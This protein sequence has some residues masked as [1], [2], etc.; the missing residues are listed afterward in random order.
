MSGALL[1][2]RSD[3]GWTASTTIQQAAAIAVAGINTK[4]AYKMAKLQSNIAQQQ[5]T[6]ANELQAHLKENYIPCEIKLLDALCNTVEPVADY[7]QQAG[8]FATTTR[9]QFAK[10]RGQLEARYSRFCCG[11]Y[12][13]MLKDVSVSEAVA[14]AD[15]INYGFRIAEARQQSLSDVRHSRLFAM[16]G[17]GRGLASQALSYSSAA[18]AAFSSLGSQASEAAGQALNE[19]FYQR[20]Q[21]R[22]PNQG[23]QYRPQATQYQPPVQQLPAVTTTTQ[24]SAQT[25]G[26]GAGNSVSNYADPYFPSYQASPNQELYF[27]DQFGVGT[28]GDD[29]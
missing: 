14:T 19:L 22:N 13:Q 17:M 5:Q 28:S 12:A 27:Q 29:Q 10:L 26:V 24:S 7:E 11:S 4:N 23:L 15:S 3:V 16:L 20:E 1:G 2:S 25:F 6:I 21:A 9:L 18:G 8:R